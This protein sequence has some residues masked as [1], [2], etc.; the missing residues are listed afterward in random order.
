MREDTTHC[1]L[2]KEWVLRLIRETKSDLADASTLYY[3][4]YLDSCDRTARKNRCSRR[5]RLR[6]GALSRFS[7]GI[8]IHYLTCARSSKP[9]VLARDFGALKWGLTNCAHQNPC[10]SLAALVAQ[11]TSETSE[12]VQATFLW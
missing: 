3:L 11:I 4:E 12:K 9:A 2:H 8:P 10:E 6:W 5:G 1:I 7:S